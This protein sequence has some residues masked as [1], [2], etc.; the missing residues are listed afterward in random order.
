MDKLY[1]VM[2]YVGVCMIGRDEERERESTTRARGELRS[3]SKTIA[4]G[5]EEE[6]RTMESDRLT[7]KRHEK[8]RDCV[9]EEGRKTELA[10]SRRERRT[11]TLLPVPEKEGELVSREKERI[12]REKEGNRTR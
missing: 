6:E 12:V 2:G 10:R 5:R 4:R 1:R 11:E 7:Q 9:P 8:D 3:R